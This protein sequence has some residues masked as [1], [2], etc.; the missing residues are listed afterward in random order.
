MGV[1]NANALALCGHTQCIGWAQKIQYPKPATQCYISVKR[2][3]PRNPRAASRPPPCRQA[4]RSPQGRRRAFQRR[5]GG[6]GRG[7]V[8]ALRLLCS[9]AK[10]FGRTLA[11]LGA[12][13][14]RWVYRVTPG[15]GA[16]PTPKTPPPNSKLSNRSARRVTYLRA[17]YRVTELR[18]LRQNQRGGT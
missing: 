11:A 7:G 13:C 16:P 14:G 4:R 1:A 2:T 12:K 10:P 17:F 18:K 3:S 8:R 15:A 9:L 5:G 6:R